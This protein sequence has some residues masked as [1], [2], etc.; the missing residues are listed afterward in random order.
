[1]GSIFQL[2]AASG[3]HYLP[4]WGQ[5]SGFAPCFLPYIAL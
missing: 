1:M 2:Q 3:S 4:F 5:K